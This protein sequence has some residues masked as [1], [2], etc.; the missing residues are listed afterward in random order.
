MS[1]RI[2]TLILLEENERDRGNPNVL[3]PIRKLMEVARGHI[4]DLFEPLQNCVDAQDERI[5]F[6]RG[7]SAPT[8]PR[9]NFPPDAIPA[10]GA[11]KQAQDK[12][13]FESPIETLAERQQRLSQPARRAQHVPARPGLHIG[14]RNWDETQ[15]ILRA[16]EEENDLHSP[17]PRRQSAVLRRRSPF[18][19]D[20]IRPSTAPNRPVLPFGQTET[21]EQRLRRQARE[22][23]EFSAS[24]ILQ[25]GES[26]LTV[27][28]STV[29]QRGLSAQELENIRLAAMSVQG[30]AQE[31]E[32]IAAAIREDRRRRHQH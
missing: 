11:L 14:H 10:K 27:P 6:G 7:H 19:D 31:E 28:V 15:A 25:N 4:E 30:Q 26:G 29:P 32:E 18:H 12:S 3:R 16:M 21:R 23:R 24:S 22:E 5:V 13:Q 20:T 9:Y 17:P 8:T 2:R 1:S